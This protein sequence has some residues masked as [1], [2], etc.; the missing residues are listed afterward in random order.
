MEPTAANRELVARA[1]ASAGAIMVAYV[2]VVHEVVGRTLYPDGPEWFGGIVGWHAAGFA[3]IAAGA[4]LLLAALGRARVPWRAIA[5]AVAAISAVVA[6]AEA[7]REHSF[8][9]FAVTNVIA[10]LAVTIALRRA[11]RIAS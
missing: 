5:G 6:L 11:G 9:L 2:G 4:L 10:A 8:H 3:T 7:V 1:L